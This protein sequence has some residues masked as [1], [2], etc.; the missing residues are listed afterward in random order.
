MVSLWFLFKKEAHRNGAQELPAGYLCLDL[1]FVTVSV[2][3][4]IQTI[5]IIIS[6]GA[7]NQHPGLKSNAQQ[8]LQLF[9]AL[10]EMCKIL[11]AGLPR[12]IKINLL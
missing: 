12:Q 10:V 4:L 9:T 8:P 7:E 6:F 2:W 5:P 1:P 11:H 3:K